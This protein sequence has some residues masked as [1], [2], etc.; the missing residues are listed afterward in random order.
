M[1]LLVSPFAGAVFFG[2][3]RIWTIAPF[4]VCTFSA[5]ILV[6]LRPFWDPNSRLIRL[7]PGM[8]CFA[9]FSVYTLGHVF[10]GGIPYEARS[11]WLMVGSLWVA[12]W[13]WAEL[14]PHRKRGQILLGLIFALA[15]GLAWYALIQHAQESTMSLWVDTEEFYGER[16]TGTYIC[17]NH[18]AQLLSMVATLGLAVLIHPGCNS[19]IRVLSGYS[20]LVCI[21]AIF[22]TFSRSGMIGLVSG[23]T[24]VLLLSLW[25]RARIVFWVSMLLGPVAVGC[26]GFLLFQQSPDFR[27]RVEGATPGQY[28]PSVL[29]RLDAWQDTVEMIQDKPFFG[30][31]AGSFR[32]AYLAYKSPSFQLW[33]RYTHN[34]YL[35]A[36]ADYGVIGFML[37]CGVLGA[38][39]FRLRSVYLHPPNSRSEVMA[40]AL[41][42]V[43]SAALAHA[44]FDFTFHIYANTHLLALLAGLVFSGQFS[45][46]ALQPRSWGSVWTRSL[47]GCG[48]L[49]AVLWIA[50]SLQLY[51]G[52][53]RVE[54]GYAAMKK[55]EY[56]LA[57][58]YYRSGAEIDGQYWK[59]WEGIGDVY[60]SKAFWLLDQEEAAACPEK[61]LEAYSRA[62]AFNRSDVTAVYAQGDLLMRRGQYHKALEYLQLAKDRN[63]KTALYWQRLGQLHLKMGHVE[64]ARRHYLEVLKLERD[65]Q[66]AIIGL[67]NLRSPE[68]SM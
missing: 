28:D 26:V 47:Y 63:P 22:I 40:L 45:V 8:I 61:A 39:L 5:W 35:Q 20:V 24:A 17:P 31:G 42:G 44:M 16:A 36:L 41:L 68:D 48:I 56:D 25:K 37:L 4:M 65:N 67:E 29:G 59:A 3:N 2:A 64:E 53:S 19:L 1:L 21:P 49:L 58:D 13:C 23:C 33:L 43:I 14:A 50:G 54:K 55:L 6:L 18:F 51:A 27:E 30:H 12:Y 46:G 62:Q 10:F 7:P 66:V 57:L 9:L 34:E 60:R 11:D 15:S 52:Y 38:V 32:W